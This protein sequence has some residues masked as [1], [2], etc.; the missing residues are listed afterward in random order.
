MLI[1]KRMLLIFIFGYGI[2]FYKAHLGLWKVLRYK[3]QRI[4]ME[5]FKIQ[6]AFCYLPWGF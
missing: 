4:H 1:L 5:P 3:S 2:E 6:E